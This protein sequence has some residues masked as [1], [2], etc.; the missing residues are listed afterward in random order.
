MKRIRILIIGMAVSLVLQS[1][2]LF[3]FDSYGGNK[4]IIYTEDNVIDKKK[5]NIEVPIPKGAFNIKASPTGK[6][7]VYYLKDSVH[8]M[9]L[10]SGKDNIIKLK[11]LPDNINVSWRSDDDRLMIIEEIGSKISVYNY[12]P[13]NNYI[14]RNLT[15]NNQAKSYNVGHDYKVSDIEQDNKNT[16]IYLKLTQKG[17]KDYSIIKTLDISNGMDGLGLPIHNIGDF[18]IYKDETKVVSEDEVDKKLYLTLSNRRT[19]RLPI[20]GVKYCKLLGV[21]NSGGIYAGEVNDDKIKNIYKGDLQ[22]GDVTG[23]VCNINWNRVTLK[24]AVYAKNIYIS[25]VG[26]MYIIDNI[27]HQ[28]LNIKDKKSISYK[29]DYVGMYG[30][31]IDGGILGLDKDKGKLIETTIR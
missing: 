8:V 4:K 27:R 21:D 24:N 25:D 5:T 15:L 11:A 18:Y 14:D 7:V 28:A 3:H 2:V 16:L 17:A 22:A 10:S 26:D 31:S 23:R 6:F 12:S 30:D 13:E 1:L 29:G 9:Q 19:V 20:E